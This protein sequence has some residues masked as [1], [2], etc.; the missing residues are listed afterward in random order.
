MHASYRCNRSMSRRRLLEGKC[1]P[2]SSRPRG[3]A[4]PVHPS[5]PPQALCLL[6]PWKRLAGKMAPELQV[7]SSHV[8]FNFE[9]LGSVFS[10]DIIHT[11]SS[12]PSQ[13]A[14]CGGFQGMHDVVQPPPP[15]NSR[16]FSSSKRNAVP[17]SSHA[18]RRTPTPRPSPWQPPA[19]FLSLICLFWALQINGVMWYMVCVCL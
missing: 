15:P 3:V 14:R 7:L 12:F 16:T 4:V 9:M 11:P 17:I 13:S 19:C 18:P 8:V 1:W 6:A 5:T 10:S 2:G